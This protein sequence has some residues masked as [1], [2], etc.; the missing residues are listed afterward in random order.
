MAAGAQLVGSAFSPHL[1]PWCH[2]SLL[3]GTEQLLTDFLLVF[4]R[5]GGIVEAFTNRVLLFNH[6]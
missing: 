4:D 1:M 6:C 5:D 2:L 3:S